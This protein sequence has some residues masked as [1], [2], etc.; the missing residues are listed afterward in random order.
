MDLSVNFLLP[1]STEQILSWEANRFSASQ[2][3]PR[4]SW[5]PKVHYRTHKSPPPVPIPSQLDPVYIRTSRFLKIHLNS[6]LPST[7]GSPKWS[8]SLGFPHQN[9][10]HTSPLL[11][12]LYMPRPSN[13]SRFYHPK[14]LGEEYR[15]LSSSLHSFLHSLVTS[16]L[17][18][19]NILL[20][21]LFS[22][23]L[24]LRPSLNVSDQ[25]S[26]PYKTRGKI[27]V[28]CILIFKF[29]DNKLEDKRFCT[30]W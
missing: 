1:Y 18:G 11:H 4:I 20:N 16:S 24:S 23:T 29:L 14:N 25:V 17:L 26:H 7:S 3:I 13:S 12:T 22:N 28:P 21:T 2:E 8:L 19:P 10:V 30:E 6:I 15:S 27:V 5:N 9:P